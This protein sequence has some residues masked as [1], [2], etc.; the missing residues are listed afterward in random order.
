MVMRVVI[1]NCVW[2]HAITNEV[3]IACRNLLA[4]IQL[5]HVILKTEL[6]NIILNFSCKSV[7]V[8]LYLELNIISLGQFLI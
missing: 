1:L 5:S 2:R 3:E 7:I 6:V 4:C 8:F